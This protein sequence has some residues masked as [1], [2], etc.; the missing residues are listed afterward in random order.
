MNAAID[1][2][3]PSKNKTPD[4][5]IHLKYSAEN[6]RKILKVVLLWHLYRLFCELFK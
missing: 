2:K 4:H 3:Y 6:E 1:L 5:S